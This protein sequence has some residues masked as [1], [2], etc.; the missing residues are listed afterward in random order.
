MSK[1]ILFFSLLSYILN[2]VLLIIIS[3]RLFNLLLLLYFS[4]QERKR[5]EKIDT[6]TDKKFSTR[7]NI[8]FTMTNDEQNV[9]T[10]TPKEV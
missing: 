9:F 1:E 6:N 5:R 7:N 8:K 4:V 10:L 3:L 2:K